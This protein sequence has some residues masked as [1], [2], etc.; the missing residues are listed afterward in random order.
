MP[1]K[2][3]ESCHFELS[4]SLVSKADQWRDPLFKRGISPSAELMFEMTAYLN[5]IVAL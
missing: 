5:N 4:E 3:K 2:I 1:L